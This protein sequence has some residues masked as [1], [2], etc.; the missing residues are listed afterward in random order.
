MC[1]GLE[2]VLEED[3]Q[4]SQLAQCTHRLVLAAVPKGT[5][6]ATELRKRIGLWRGNRL[7]EL[8][9][10]VEHQ[11]S[12]RESGLRLTVAETDRIKAKR[13]E[14]LAREGARSKAIAGFKGGI[15]TL[16]PAE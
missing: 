14:R 7:E 5:H 10:R 3:A 11:S 12:H 16:E 6:P 8:L 1:D 15:K 13:V 4:W 9:V 2:G